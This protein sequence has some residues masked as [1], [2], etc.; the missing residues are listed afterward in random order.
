MS[1]SLLTAPEETKKA[2]KVQFIAV[3]PIDEQFPN[4]ESPHGRT[5]RSAE[6]SRKKKALGE[7]TSASLLAA[8]KEAKKALQVQFTA[9]TPIDEQF[10]D[11][12]SPHG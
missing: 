11:D 1:A 3:T 8:S 12:K 2:L 6:W 5:L 10:P 7:K 4:G 9:V